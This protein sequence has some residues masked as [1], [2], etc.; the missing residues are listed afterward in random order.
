MGTAAAVVKPR[1][2]L[3]PLLA[4]TAAAA[5][6][7]VV[8]GRVLPRG[9]VTTHAAL[10]TMATCLLAGMVAGILGR[11]RWTVVPVVVGFASAFELVRLDAAGPTVDGVHLTSTYG[12]MAFVVGR[13]LLAL[14]WL[15]P[16]AVGV[17]LGAAVARRRVRAGAP[18]TSRRGFGWLLRTASTGVAIL[19]LLLLAV[20][21]AR[22]ASTDQIVGPDGHRLPGSVA[23]LTTIQVDGHELT[24]MIRGRDA[25]SPVL[26]FLAGGPGGSELG[27][28]RRH[29]TGLEDDFVVAT[30]DQRGTGSSHDELEPVGTLTLDRA[31]ADVLEVT[32]YLRTRFDEESVVLVGQS[33]G[34]TLGVLAAQERPELFRAFVGVG[35]MVSQSATDQI[36][37]ADTLDWARRQGDD[38]LVRE[39]EAIGP[40]PYANILDYETALA[41]EHEV[42]PYDHSQNSEGEGGFSENLFVE[43]YTLLEQVHNLG[44]FLD[45]FSVMYP[46]LQEIDFRR[47]V[48]RL[49]VPVF[50]VQGRFEAAGRSRLAE[51]WFDLLQAP[52]KEMTILDTSGHRAIFEQPEEF[53]VVMRQL[54][55]RTETG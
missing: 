18:R 30:F 21:L 10:L 39:L 8:L 42:Y 28:M 33:W 22:P 54:L 50:L 52:V 24:L 19:G 26:L 4:A 2:V 11:T 23:E 20:G 37:Y 36:F 51:E 47:D 1:R 53:Q 5:L 34:S 16:L 40:P 14:I 7:G 38:G 48:P 29:A 44:A 13:G 49:E 32:D 3:L 17:I 6:F 45:V 46:Q 43:E 55:E 25:D 27:A 12:V 9:P 35:Q 15:A 31:V 41:Y